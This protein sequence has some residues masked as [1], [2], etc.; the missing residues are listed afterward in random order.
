M[1]KWDGLILL[2]IKKEKI[3]LDWRKHQ[4][5]RA[6]VKVA[7]KNKLEQLPGCYKEI[8]D[9]KCNLLY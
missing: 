6:S 9:Q 7:I 1:K 4:T 5:S 3:T 2:I 8:Y